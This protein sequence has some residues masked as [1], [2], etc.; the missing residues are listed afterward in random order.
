MLPSV[1]R[2]VWAEMSP[3][4]KAKLARDDRRF[5]VP[6]ASEINS[7]PKATSP[8]NWAEVEKGKQR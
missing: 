8:W 5:C 7:W 1:T 2:L 4:E 6:R 3:E